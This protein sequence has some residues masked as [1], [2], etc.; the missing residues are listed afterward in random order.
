MP[1]GAG[2]AY[3]KCVETADP[4][5]CI[6]R[7]AV[8]SFGLSPEET[9]E[10][11][12]RHG[13]VDLVPRKS[14]KL[15]RGLYK[16]VGAKHQIDSEAKAA[17]RQG[18]RKSLL[19]AVALLAAARHETNP[20]DDPIYLELARQAKEDPRIPV[21][22]F[23][24]WTEI[25]ETGGSPPDFSV[26]H[27]GLPAIWDRAMA[28]KEQDTL[29]LEDIAGSIVFNDDWKPRA[30]E[31]LLWYA[32]RPDLT[33]DQRV[34]TALRFTR[35][36]DMP[37]EAASLLEGIGE[38]GEGF[39]IPALRDSIA[40]AR[41]A[42]G[43]DAAS[44]KRVMDSS[45]DGLARHAIRFGSLEDAN[46]DAL[47]RSGAREE[48]RELG[49]E[50]LRRAEVLRRAETPG[51]QSQSAELLAAASDAYLRAGDR[52]RAR[53]IARLGLPLVCES[54][55]ELGRDTSPVIALYRTGAIEEA[56]NTHCLTGTHRYLNAERAGEKR[57]PRWILDENWPTHLEF[58]AGEALRSSE[59]EF[60]RTVLDGL[61]RSCE[62]PLAE[63]NDETL[64][65][66]AEI[67]ASMGDEPRTTEAL[68]AAARQLG[69]A[70][71]ALYVAG[72]WAHCEE[73]LRAAQQSRQ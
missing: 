7:R 63:C 39:D 13:L 49:A 44:A 1:A 68:R 16:S 25:L 23:S 51:A 70:L 38:D 65:K 22:A 53:E 30:K 4:A 18:P 62:K 32:R 67:A 60:K 28:R 52:E 42:R 73:V 5:D 29:L 54:V 72:P 56:L 15:V 43:Y 61:V 34:I 21:L 3:S 41:L 66:I 27:A 69:T 47:E 8:G 6:A 58:M 33:Q 59:H 64:R 37:E 55:K 11:V 19:A 48:L 36:F 50:Y 12:L 35:N 20:F 9:L 46:R 14:G 10:A 40:L 57:D 71:S 45:L 31:F 17:L 26:T 2:S 24:L